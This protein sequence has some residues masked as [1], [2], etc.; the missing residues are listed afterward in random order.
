MDDDRTLLG[1]AM[2]GLSQSRSRSSS[3]PDIDEKY[4]ETIKILLSCGADPN[5]KTAITEYY[6]RFSSDIPILKA[7]SIGSIEL[8]KVLLQHG[9]NADV[10]DDWGLKASHI[11]ALGDQPEI[12]GLLLATST[13]ADDSTRTFFKEVLRIH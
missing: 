4:I 2:D 1:L 6:S 12:A 8:V 11:A 3:N 10:E 7:I 5:E 9:A 13:D